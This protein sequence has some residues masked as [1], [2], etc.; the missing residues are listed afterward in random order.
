[1]SGVEV[2]PTNAD[3]LQSSRTWEI[4]RSTLGSR[5][6]GLVFVYMLDRHHYSSHLLTLQSG[7]Y[8]R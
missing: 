1:V 5:W 2:D 4:R 6:E 3:I 7:G 8:A